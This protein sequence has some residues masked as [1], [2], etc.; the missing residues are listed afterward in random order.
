MKRIILTIGVVSMA[1]ALSGLAYIKGHF[2]EVNHASLTS[3]CFDTVAF[4]D[5]ERA[6]PDRAKSRLAMLVTCGSD[7]LNSRSSWL[8][9]SPNS[10]MR[11]WL[12]WKES[13]NSSW[14]ERHRKRAEEIANQ[15]RSTL[16]TLAGVKAALEK[17][18]P[19]VK[20]EF[21]TE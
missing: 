20:I 13:K 19:D 2:D 12:E 7:S 18:L 10:W 9:N 11:N 14:V 6:G 8:H 4:D 5:F 16:P 1:L 21:K 3:L 15:Y 17:S